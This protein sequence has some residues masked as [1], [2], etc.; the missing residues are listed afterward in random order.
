MTILNSTK[1]K[2]V[3]SLTAAAFLA[4]GMAAVPTDASAKNWKGKHWHHHHHSGWH[5]G[6][7]AL[8]GGLALGALAASSYPAY[9]DCYTVRRRLVDD[10][11]R[12]FVRRV[13]VCD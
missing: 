6:G 1:T 7:A 9:A 11:G 2:A 5:Y 8:V 3:L 12:V 10:Y 4:V 13:R